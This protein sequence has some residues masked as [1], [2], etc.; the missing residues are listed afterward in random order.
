M[1]LPLGYR[2]PLDF[3]LHA[4]AMTDKTQRALPIR[5]GDQGPSG[6]KFQQV[7]FKGAGAQ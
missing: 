6:V 5:G 7:N 4:N 3:L 2:D 1:Y